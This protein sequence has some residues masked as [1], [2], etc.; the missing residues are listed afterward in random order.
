MRLDIRLL[1]LARMTY[2]P[3]RSVSARSAPSGAR[4]W[5]SSSQGFTN[6]TPPQALS[7]ALCASR[8]SGG[9]ASGR[10]R[11]SG[12]WATCITTGPTAKARRACGI[13]ACSRTSRRSATPSASPRTSAPSTTPTTATPPGSIGPGKVIFFEGARITLEAHIA[14]YPAQYHAELRKVLAIG[15]AWNPDRSSC[16][17][18]APTRSRNTS[19]CR[20]RPHE[21]AENMVRRFRL[22]DAEFRRLAPLLSEHGRDQPRRQGIPRPRR[23]QLHHRRR[24][25]AAVHRD[26]VPDH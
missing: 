17:R 15:D 25:P 7:L 26:S 12:S 20:N 13:P 9:P 5:P 4:V 11:S 21:A 6:A 3:L 23:P 16:S 24:R 19:G 1:P 10:A 22:I 2:S 18:R 8:S 14:E